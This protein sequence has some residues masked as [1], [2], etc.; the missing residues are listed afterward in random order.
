MKK[1]YVNSK[2]LANAREKNLSNKKPDD[3]A[4]YEPVSYRQILAFEEKGA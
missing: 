1:G 4:Q 3:V 2:F